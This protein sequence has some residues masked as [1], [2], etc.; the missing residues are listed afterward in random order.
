M[1]NTLDNTNMSLYLRGMQKSCTDMF[2]SSEQMYYGYMNTT[3]CPLS[4]DVRASTGVVTVTRG[5][6]R[7]SYWTI[8][9]GLLAAGAPSH[10]PHTILSTRGYTSLDQGRKNVILRK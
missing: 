8:F 3:D 10:P 4:L 1:K 2:F 7:L 6:K 9:R 5:G